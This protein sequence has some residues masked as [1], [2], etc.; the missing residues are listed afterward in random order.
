MGGRRTIKIRKF[1]GEKSLKLDILKQLGVSHF[2]LD[3]D[4]DFETILDAYFAKSA[5]A[6]LVV[7]ISIRKIS[8]DIKFQLMT[9]SIVTSPR[10]QN[11]KMG[12]PFNRWDFVLEP[13]SA[14]DNARRET[15]NEK[16]YRRRISELFS[17]VNKLK[18]AGG[19]GVVI[20]EV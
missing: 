11:Q 1:N 8:E 12:D 20:N 16:E 19:E 14:E 9:K 13:I 3:G 18:A 5:N 7:K 10:P 17:V 4:S 6:E 15:E 2:S